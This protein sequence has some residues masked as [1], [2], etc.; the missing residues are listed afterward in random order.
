[1]LATV[2]L[3]QK[4][5]LLGALAV[6]GLAALFVV[7]AGTLIAI[8]IGQPVVVLVV[9]AHLA[10][11]AAIVVLF[12]TLMITSSKD[13]P[14]GE[15]VAVGARERLIQHATELRTAGESKRK[16]TIY[17]APSQVPPLS[18]SQPQKRRR[19]APLPELRFVKFPAPLT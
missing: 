14:A 12:S 4:R 19:L 10:M 5:S 7:V 16:L 6:A 1:M 2:L 13:S 18:H 9:T 8:A 3:S 17:V 11:T 15:D